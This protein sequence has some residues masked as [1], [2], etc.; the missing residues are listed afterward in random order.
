MITTRTCFTFLLLMMPAIVRAYPLENTEF[1]KAAYCFHISSAPKLEVDLSNIEKEEGRHRFFE[2]LLFRGLEFPQGE[3]YEA[4][5]N[6]FI[7]WVVPRF[8]NEPTDTALIWYRNNCLAKD[9]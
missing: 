1:L 4:I 5:Q 2:A 7:A 3:N 9:K 6:K 8:R